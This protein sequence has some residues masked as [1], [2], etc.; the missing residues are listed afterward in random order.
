MAATG[1]AVANGYWEAKLTSNQK[2]HYE[3][4]DLEP[5][6]RRKYCNKEFAEGIWPPALPGEAIPATT[7]DGSPPHL[8]SDT[9]AGRLEAGGFWGSL[10]PQESSVAVDLLSEAPPGTSLTYVN[11]D[12]PALLID[13][14][15]FGAESTFQLPTTPRRRHNPPGSGFGSAGSGGMPSAGGSRGRVSGSTVPGAVPSRLDSRKQGDDNAVAAVPGVQ[16][17]QLSSF[18]LLRPPPQVQQHLPNRCIALRLLL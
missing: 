17:Q 5:F 8:A 10:T 2:P 6:I 18:P 9:S 12:S 3:S 13:L 1:N 4:S 14:M 16:K 11:A 7:A 15:D